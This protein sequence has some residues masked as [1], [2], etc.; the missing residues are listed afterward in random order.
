MSLRYLRQGSPLQYGQCKGCTLHYHT[1]YSKFVISPV[2]DQDS[3]RHDV[4]HVAGSLSLVRS[5]TRESLGGCYVQVQ[6]YGGGVV[7]QASDVRGT[8]YPLQLPRSEP[9]CLSEHGSTSVVS[10]I[11]PQNLSRRTRRL[12]E[13]W[14]R[15]RYNLTCSLLQ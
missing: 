8:Q 11:L 9:V 4:S 12:S 14:S 15:W 1:W 10:L 13:D 6:G 5:G 3:L 2:P 7:S